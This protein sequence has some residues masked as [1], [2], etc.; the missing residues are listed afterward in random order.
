MGYILVIISALIGVVSQMMLKHSARLQHPSWWREYINIWVIGGYS[1][2]V[3]SLVVNL[4]AIHMGIL[5]QE[6]SIIECINYLLI[7][8]AAWLVFHEPITR[9]KALA[10]AIILVGV[11]VFFL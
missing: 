10:I 6:V 3:L 7:P 1:F 2:M 11:V 8:I 4:L 9:R 5:A